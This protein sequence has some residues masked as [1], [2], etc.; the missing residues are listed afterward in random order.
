MGAA[1]GADGQPKRAGSNAVG[2]R[3]LVTG[4]RRAGDGVGQH[5]GRVGPL[6]QAVGAVAGGDHRRSTSPARGPPGRGRR[7]RWAAARPGSRGRWRRPEPGATSRH[8]RSSSWSPAAVTSTENPAP[9][10]KVPPQATRPP[11]H[12][13][14]VVREQR[15]RDGPVARLGL[16]AEMHDLPL[17][18][19]DRQGRPSHSPIAAVHAPPATASAAHS[20]LR[21]PSIAECHRR[22]ARRRSPATT[23]CTEPSTK[24]DA[25]CRGGRAAD[26][27]A[28]PRPST[29]AD[30]GRVTA[31]RWTGPSGGKS[32]AASVGR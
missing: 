10:S 17:R 19:S 22:V 24:I 2:Q 32:A 26:A 9:G 27:A 29:R 4:Q 25:A 15:L 30:A 11:G 6:Q 12:G 31:P 23:P 3:R 28:M 8:S 21:C 5:P 7:P 1:R 18:R 16:D 13:H 14:E 20:T